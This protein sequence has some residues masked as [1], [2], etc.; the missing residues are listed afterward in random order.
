MSAEAKEKLGEAAAA[1][2]QPGQLVGL[3]SGSTAAC[4][5]KA[6]A[7]RKLDI[8]CVATSKA[9]EELARSLGLK[10]VEPRAGIDICVDGADEVGPNKALVKGGGGALLREKIVARLSKK[11]VILVEKR[12][13][14]KE[15]GAFGL[16]LELVCFGAEAT[17]KQVE[18]H[19]RGKAIMRNVLSDEGHVLCDFKG[20]LADP[21][22]VE[23]KLRM[24]PGVVTTGLFLGFNP[25]ILE[26]QNGVI[27][28]W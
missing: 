5:V 1:L 24:L 2:I 7:R 8:A 3:G 26:E 4:F 22:A 21:E 15:L 18:E 10:M 17:R 25:L 27:K 6:L 14:V 16:P 28:Q 19:L 11:L 20:S 12:K 23:A 9:T 13:V